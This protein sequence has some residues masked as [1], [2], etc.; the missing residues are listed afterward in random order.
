MN[1][2]KVIMGVFDQL[3]SH[4][5]SMDMALDSEATNA[6]EEVVDGN[7]T[8]LVPFTSHYCFT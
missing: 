7:G 2:W 3:D 4:G 1:K 5:V 6:N 8:V